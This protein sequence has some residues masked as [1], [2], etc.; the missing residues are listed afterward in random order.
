MEEEPKATDPTIAAR[1][2]LAT[3]PDAP[4]AEHVREALASADRYETLCAEMQEENPGTRVV[5]CTFREVKDGQ[6]RMTLT[7]ARREDEQEIA[8][9]LHAIAV[10]YGESEQ[11][12]KINAVMARLYR[13]AIAA[14]GRDNQMLALM[15]E[16][17]ELLTAINHFRR[18]RIGRDALLGEIA[19]VR[20]M[21]G[22]LEVMTGGPNACVGD[23]DSV[24]VGKLTRLKERLDERDRERADEVKLEKE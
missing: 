15:E 19:D 23:A 12:G 4:G 21:L 11:R 3:N 13:R 9:R 10:S 1:D 20:V 7:A 24:M 14:Y 18:G 16:I 2:W 17:G 8:H 22:Q 6:V 5:I